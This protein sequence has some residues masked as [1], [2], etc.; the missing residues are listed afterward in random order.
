MKIIE[1]LIF[2]Q[3]RLSSVI[4]RGGTLYNK[5]QMELNRSIDPALKQPRRFEVLLLSLQSNLYITALYSGTPNGSVPQNICSSGNFS[6][7]GRFG[8]NNMSL[9]GEIVAGK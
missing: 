4:E 1:C 5:T 2:D 8:K 7:A 3:V 9:K 6:L